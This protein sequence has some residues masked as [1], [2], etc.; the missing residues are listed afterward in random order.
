[1]ESR[2]AEGDCKKVTQGGS[3]FLFLAKREI[4]HAKAGDYYWRALI[5]LYRNIIFR[6]ARI[7]LSTLNGLVFLSLILLRVLTLPR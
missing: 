2:T 5:M 6:P 7:M 3:A 4:T 1:M